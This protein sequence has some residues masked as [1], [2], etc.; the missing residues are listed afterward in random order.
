MKVSSLR[1]L[2]V[3]LPLVVTGC[4]WWHA[5][6]D[7]SSDALARRQG[8][9]VQVTE[10][11][12]TPSHRA[13]D[14][15]SVAAWVAPGGQTWLIAT[16]KASDQLVVYDGET[17]ERLSRFGRAGAAPGQFQRP[18]DIAVYGDLL[19]VV[20]RDNHRVQVLQLP[21]F[22]TL[23]TFGEKE[24]RSPHG[25]WLQ[26]T[27]SDALTVYVTDSFMTDHKT[28]Q[29]PPR[30]P[31]DQRIKRFHVVVDGTA[32][33]AGYVGPFGDTRTYSDCVQC[34]P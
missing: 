15:D 31:L 4:G 22:A 11:F 16:A 2:L 13:D 8:D 7:P 9:A 34:L 25:L 3:S 14:I 30:G 21:D 17:G 19:F 10:A 23:A 20:E 6:H 12:M 27:D 33:S 18:N 24:L 26:P 1:V 32:I 29:V 5:R 28:G